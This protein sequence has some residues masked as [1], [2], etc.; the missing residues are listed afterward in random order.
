MSALHAQVV[1]DF[2]PNQRE[3]YGDGQDDQIHIL[4][5]RHSPLTAQQEGQCP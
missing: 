1:Q 2:E 5:I 3:K 4:K